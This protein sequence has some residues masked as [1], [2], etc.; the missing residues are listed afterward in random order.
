MA[1]NRRKH[2]RWAAVVADPYRKLAAI[3]LAVGLWFYLDTQV[4]QR[5]DVDFTLQAVNQAARTAPEPEVG[6]TLQVNLPLGV[7]SVRGF[8]N[9][10]T[11]RTLPEVK[12][13]FS[14][15]KYV[16]ESLLGA[17]MVLSVG[18]FQDRKWDEIEVLEFSAAD[19]RRTDR[20]LQSVTL[21]MDPPRVRINLERNVTKTFTLKADLVELQFRPG[22]EERLRQR[23]RMDRTEFTRDVLTVRGPKSR[24]DGFPERGRSPFRA[25]VEPINSERQ[26]A[27]AIAIN[28]GDAALVLDAQT[29]ITIPLIPRHSEFTVELPIR[30]DDL[31]LPERLRGRYR[32]DEPTKLVKIKASGELES[33]LLGIGD[34][35]ER[36]RWARQHLRL[37]VWIPPRDETDSYPEVDVRD[38]RL[39]LL[40]PMAARLDPINYILDGAVSVI[41][42]QQ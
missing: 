40:H 18:P 42:R 33:K 4:S 11:E 26:V 12:I 9:P 24:V 36:L 3:A 29:T 7:V 34:P 22:D 21:E 27:G 2:S 37:A 10:A 15:P 6:K 8:V 31:S 20:L 25:L 5:I 38:A 23:L 19:I 35:E 1:D 13:W 16:V 28:S 14:G 41:L 32:P 30:V 39:E 17:Q